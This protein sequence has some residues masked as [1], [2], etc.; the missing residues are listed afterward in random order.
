MRRVPVA[1]GLPE[2]RCVRMKPKVV[3]MFSGCGGFDLGFKWAGFDLVWANDISKEACQTYRT[4]ISDHIV[5]GDVNEFR[6][7]DLPSADV[8]IGGPPCQPF[9]LV[10]KRNLMDDRIDLIWTFVNAVKELQPQ[11]FV[12][13]NVV[14]LKSAVDRHGGSIL[15]K[16]LRRLKRMGYSLNYAVMNAAEFGVPQLRRRLILMGSLQKNPL[17]FPRATHALDK[18]SELQACVSS[19]EAIGD[20]P[21]PTKDDRPTGYGTPASSLYQ[22]WVRSKSRKVHN[23]LYP[24]MSELDKLIISYIPPGGNYMD[25]PSSV[26]SKRIQKFKETGGR[27]TTYGRL[28]KDR[29]SYTLNTH[30]SRPNV[31]C[32]IHFR[33]DRLIT[34]REGLRF[35]SFPDSFVLPQG[36]SKRAQYMLVGNAVPPLMAFAIANALKPQIA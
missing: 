6:L 35:Q 7:G 36:L 15:D 16:I 21:A 2:R 33:Q 24:H 26:P 8:L 12:M 30:F 10:G 23:H 19:F 17:Q 29:P 25:V 32:N 13:E 18:A 3:S 14:G 1:K 27:T 34:I 4:N 31:G 22:K 5:C 9:S 20:L 11:A 28:R